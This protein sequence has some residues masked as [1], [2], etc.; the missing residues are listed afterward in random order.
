MR[1]W[2]WLMAVG[3]VFCSPV[4]ALAQGLLVNA[5]V[6]QRIRLPR[7][8]PQP[9]P[10]QSSYRIKELDVHVRLQDQVAK[11]QVTQSFVNTGSQQ[12][13]VSFVF[14]LPHDG[15]IDQLTFL[16][17][18]KEFPGKLMK[19]DEARRIYEET[20]RRNR[21]PALLE[22]LGTGMFQTS[23][24]PVPPGAERKV[25]LS[26]SQL[27]RRERG[28]TDF[29]F[30]LSTA[31]Y[32]SQPV[33]KLN[34]QVNVTSGTEIK[35]V[36]SPTH[37]VSVDR[38]GGHAT[39]K[40]TAENTIPSNDFRLFYDVGSDVLGTSVVSY[41][42]CDTE[43]GYFLMLA[44]PDVKADSADIPA[45]TVVFVVDRSGSMSGEKIEQ[46]KGALKFVLNNL[47]DGDMF[48]IVAYDT[49]VESF[50]PELEKFNDDTRKAALGFVE[51]IYA[52][53]STNI[54]GALETA[55]KQLKDSTRPSYVVFL[56]DG[57]PTVGETNEMKIVDI[58]KQANQVRA[59]VLA[60]GVGYDVNSRMLDRLVRENFGQSEYVRPN[61]DIEA[62]VASLYNRIKLPVMTDVKVTFDIDGLKPEEGGAVNRVYPSEVYDLFAGEQIVLVGR[63]KKPGAAKVTIRGKVQGSER[64]FDFPAEFAASSMDDSFGFVEKLWAMRRIGEIIDELDLKGQNDELVQELVALATQH[65]VLTPYTSFLADEN[66][67]IRDLA[68]N[69]AEARVQLESLAETDGASAVGQRAAKAG[70]QRAGG[71]G[72][73]GAYDR[74]GESRGAVAGRPAGG[75]AYGPGVR[76]RQSAPVAGQ[77]VQDYADRAMTESVRNVAQKTF[78]RRSNRWIDSIVSEEQEKKAQRVVQFS[79]DYF[80]LAN[81]HG[82]A[83]SQYLVFDEPLLIA[84]DGETYLIEPS[85]N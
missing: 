64:T 50:R 33:E 13:E 49:G 75:G 40:Y 65:G 60:F 68:K 46:A 32:T 54:S 85:E 36:Y 77:P 6:Q 51:G 61:E 82:R 48:N 21:D 28:L 81:R 79:D 66:T 29:L 62:R 35:N 5:D 8:M 34:V 7:P 3:G 53:G 22:W 74:F 73:G 57:L 45:K 52:G 83:L 18:G 37:S 70:L 10:P 42:S 43:D 44:T 19:A 27:C 59:R 63:Y 55:L 72:G 69:N 56:T 16:V 25:T 9:T 24:F 23:V 20:V 15:A 38:S 39:I 41:R 12:M 78:Y 14:P 76:G 71:Y 31:K 26:Y 84:L 67:N 80:T 47:R 4:L 17:D 2:I 30:P 1:R 11:V 58:A